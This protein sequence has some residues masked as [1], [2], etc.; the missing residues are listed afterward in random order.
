MKQ[1]KNRNLHVVRESEDP[2]DKS[3]GR[4]YGQPEVEVTEREIRA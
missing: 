1:R 2:T 4:L 3:A